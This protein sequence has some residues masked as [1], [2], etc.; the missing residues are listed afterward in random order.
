MAM[1]LCQPALANPE[2]AD[3]AVADTPEGCGSCHFDTPVRTDSSALR[4][5]GLPDH[6]EAGSTHRLTLILEDP[7]LANAGF[8]LT[9]SV[10]GE[11]AG[12]DAGRFS[13]QDGRTETNG[14]RARSTL[15]GSETATEGR[16]SWA[17]DWTAPDPLTGPLR[18][19]LW[20]NA[21]NDD[22]SAFGDRI[23]RL[24]VE[25]PVTP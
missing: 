5:E 25:R 4:I 22:L 2:G 19:D 13:G 3:W 24:T 10:P 9:V 6:P 23:H 11:A 15:A 7:K 1:A 14:A 16:T 17:V 8:L 12:A 18:F 20:G 21:G